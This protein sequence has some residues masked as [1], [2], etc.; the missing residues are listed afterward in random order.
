MHVPM[1]SYFNML[2]GVAV[3]GRVKWY[4]KPVMAI[5]MRRTPMMRDLTVGFPMVRWLGQP[6]LDVEF[7]SRGSYLSSPSRL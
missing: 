5:E 2:S 4:T 3:R 6:Q 1:G 7:R